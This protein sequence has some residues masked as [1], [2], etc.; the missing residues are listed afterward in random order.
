MIKLTAP[1]GSKVK[2]NGILVERV[3]KALYGE[4]AAA[5]TRVWEV[6]SLVKEAV[7]QVVPL[8][9]AEL[10]SLAALTALEGK[11]VWFNAKK[12][13]GPLPITRAQENYGYKSSIKIM[14]YRQYVIE[15]PD[16][17][18]T[19]IN[20]AGGTPLNGSE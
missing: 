19:V 5:Q 3:R 4:N 11:K 18:R 17:V 6:V 20:A 14:R 12:A 15:T 8:V 7:E 1:N 10:P 16:E 13:I 9:K 2:V